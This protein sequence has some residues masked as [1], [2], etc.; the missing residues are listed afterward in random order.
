MQHMMQLLHWWNCKCRFC[1]LVLVHNKVATPPSLH[2][3]ESGVIFADSVHDTD[4]GPSPLNTK[5]IAGRR[6]R[7]VASLVNNV[8]NVIFVFCF[9]Y[10]RFSDKSSTKLF[11]HF[12]PP[13]IF[14]FFSNLCRTLGL[15]V[16]RHEHPISST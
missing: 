4:H 9:F 6:Q 2:S 15:T 8:E 11:P 10:F 3:S 1:C 16:R 12:P 5:D 7:H 13:F 14:F